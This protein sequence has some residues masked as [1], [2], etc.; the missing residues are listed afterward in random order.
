MAIGFGTL[1]VVGLTVSVV[2]G[3]AASITDSVT[4]DDDKWGPNNQAVAIVAMG[5][6]AYGIYKYGG[7]YKPG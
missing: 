5:L 7:F 3:S 4:N 1:L 2:A 6:V